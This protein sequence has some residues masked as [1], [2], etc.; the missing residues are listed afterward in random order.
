MHWTDGACRP[1]KAAVDV[2]RAV[3]GLILMTGLLDD[4]LNSSSPTGEPHEVEDV[5]HWLACLGELAKAVL[6]ASQK[7]QQKTPVTAS[8]NGFDH[9]G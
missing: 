1:A 5:C 7:Q 2:V 6:A 8:L 9:K 3:N 4:R